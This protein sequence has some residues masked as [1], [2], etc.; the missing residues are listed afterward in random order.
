[1]KGEKVVRK[2]L[3]AILLVCCLIAPILFRNPLEAEAATDP[4]GFNLKTPEDFKPDDGENPYGDG[5]VAL[6]PKM[7]PFVMRSANSYLHVDYWNDVKPDESNGI[8][9]GDQVRLVNRN[10][11]CAADYVV[12]KAYDPDGDGHDYMVAAVGLQDQDLVLWN[13]NSRTKQ[14]GPDK[15]VASFSG[16]A[17]DWFDD[18][19]QWEYT[20]FFNLTAG[21]FDGDGKDELAVYVPMRG[22]PYVSILEQ[23]GNT[24]DEVD[25]VHYTTFMPGADISNT[26]TNDG[27]TERAMVQASLEAADMDRDGKDE[28]IFLGSF[29]NLH[30][31]DDTKKI[32]D[33]SSTLAIY[34]DND[35]D[36]LFMENWKTF[37]LNNRDSTEFDTTPI[38][39]RTASC[40]AGDIDYDGFPEI[41]VAGYYVD[42]ADAMED[43]LNGDMFALQTLD[44]EPAS[45][46]GKLGEVSAGTIRTV[47][48]NGWVDGGLYTGDDIQAPPA[49]TCVAANGRNAKEQVFLEGAMY[50]FADSG[51]T[52]KATAS[53]CQDGQDWQWGYM[54]SNTYVESAVAGNFDGN[55]MGIEQVYF[56][57]GYKQTATN[58]YFY[59]LCVMGK[60]G[61]GETTD[62]DYYDKRWSTVH[63]HKNQKDHLFLTVAAVDA[64][65]DTDTI[66]Y[67]RKEYTYT[68]ANVMAV[69][70]AAPYFED[71]KD[72]Y[73]DGVGETVFGRTTGSGGSTSTTKSASAGAYFNVEIP[74]FLFIKMDIGATYTHD[75]EWEYE[76]EAS[77]EYSIDFAG[78]Q[79]E[80]SVV[81]YRT[82]MTLYYYDVYPAGGGET[83]HMTV[84]VPDSPVYSIMSKEEYNAVAATDEN[85]KDKVITSNVLSSTPGQPSTYNNSAAGLK[86]FTGYQEFSSATATSTGNIS[87]SITKGSQESSSQSYNNTFELSIGVSGGP[88]G[89]G[90][91]GGGGWGGGSTTFE[92]EEVSKT[93]MVANPPQSEY[94]YSFQWKFGT[95][96]ADLGDTQVPV[97]GYIVNNVIEPPSLPQNIAV[98]SVTQDSITLTWDHG[99]RRP[100]TYEIYQYF[101]DNVGD[102]GYSLVATVD[103]NEKTFTY[104]GLKPGNSYSLALRS[105]GADENGEKTM[106][107]YSALVTGTTLQ[108]G[109]ELSVDSITEEVNVCPGDTAVFEVEATPSQGA[110]NGLS[111]S[112]QVQEEDSATWENVQSGNSRLIL[113][114]VTEEMD[115]NRYRCIVSEIQNG[116]RYYVYS[117]VGVL[118]VGKA[119]SSVS[120]ATY[121]DYDN[122]AKKKTNTGSA[123]YVLAEQGEATETEVIKTISVKTPA[124]VDKDGATRNESVTANYQVFENTLYQAESVY[125]EAPDDNQIEPCIYYCE[126]DNAYYALINLKEEDGTGTADKRILLTKLDDYFAT[127]KAGTTV[128]SGL[129]PEDLQGAQEVYTI[130]TKGTDGQETEGKRY[131]TWQVVQ[132]FEDTVTDEEGISKD[133]IR[134]E[135]LFLLYSEV[136]DA[137]DDSDAGETGESGNGEEPTYYRLVNDA[138]ESWNGKDDSGKD[139][140]FGEDSDYGLVPVYASEPGTE[141]FNGTTYDVWTDRTDNTN[142]EE[143]TI[144]QKEDGTYYQK[145]TNDDNTEVME[146]IYLITGNLTGTEKGEEGETAVIYPANP[147]ANPVMVME[148]YTPVTYTDQ[149]GKQVTLEAKVTHTQNEGET[150]KSVAGQVMF[151]IVNNRTGEVTTLSGEANKDGLVSVNWTPK[152]AGYYTITATFGGNDVLHPSSASTE[153][154]ATDGPGASVGY[155]LTKE[156]TGDVIYGDNVDLELKK[157]EVNEDGNVIL[158]TPENNVSV[159]YR[160]QYVDLDKVEAEETTGS[161][162][163]SGNDEEANK[164]A[165]KNET[166]SGGNAQG[167]SYTPDNM[168]GTHTFT[169]TV[170]EG[171]NTYTASLSVNVLKRPI[172]MTAPSTEEPLSVNSQDKIPKLSQ[173][174]VTYTGDETKNA[175]AAEEDATTYA[176][177]NVLQNVIT[178]PVLNANSGA[179]NYVTSLAYQTTGEG[180][181]EQNTEVVQQFLNRYDVTLE[182]GLY[183]IESGIYDVTYAAG[184]NGSLQALKD[185]NQVAFTSGAGLTEGTEVRF[186][187]HPDE[188]FKVDT[189]TVNGDSVTEDT[190]EYKLTGNGEK[191]IFKNLSKNLDVKVTFEPASYELSYLVDNDSADNGTISAQYLTEEGTGTS[192]QSG[193]D[194]FSGSGVR[195]TAE[196][197]DGY[198]VDQWTIRRDGEEQ[199]QVQKNEDGSDYAKNTLDIAEMDSNMT[200]TV[201]FEEKGEPFAITTSMVGEDGNQIAGGSIEVTGDGYIADETNE[202]AGTAVKGSEVTFT[203]NLPD[204]MIVREWRISDGEGTMYDEGDQEYEVV[205]GSQDTYTVYNVQSNLKVQVMATTMQPFKVTYGTDP[206]T[207]GNGKI[208]SLQGIKSG[209][210]VDKYYYDTLE[211]QISPK[212]GYEI[213]TIAVKM[214]AQTVSGGE[215]PSTDASGTGG[216]V[217]TGNENALTYKTE[218]IDNS[219]DRKLIVSP[220]EG[221]FSD[222]VEVTVSFKQITPCVDVRYS[223]HDLGDGTHGTMTAAVDR[224]GDE[225]YVETGTAVGTGSGTGDAGSDLETATLKGVYRDSVITF[226]AKPDAGYR[227]GKWTV[228]GVE[229]TEGVSGNTFTY[230]ITDE[231]K[232]PITVVAQMEWIGNQVTFGGVNVLEGEEPVGGTVSAYNNETG[233]AF[234][235]GNTLGIDSSL[236]FTAAPAAGYEVVG[237]RV[238][239]EEV[240]DGVSADK[241]TFTSQIQANGFTEVQAV[242]DQIPYTVN[243]SAEGGTVTVKNTSE[244]NADVTNGSEVRGGRTLAFT[245]AANTGMEFSG[246]SVTGADIDAEK[247]NTSPL[248]LTIGSDV[249]V[250]ANFKM[251]DEFALNFGSN[252]EDGSM[253]TLTAKVGDKTLTS[254]EKIPSNSKVTFTAAP[255]EGYLV[256]GWYSNATTMTEETKITGTEY[257][258]NEYVLDGLN[259][260]T[261]VYV[262]FEKI[263]SYNITVDTD[264]TGSGSLEVFVD[265]KA[266]TP[267]NTGTEADDT[268]AGTDG[269]GIYSVK[270]HSKVEVKATPKN[271]FHKLGAWN[272]KKAESDT[273]IIEDVKGEAS[274]TATF[275]ARE[276]VKVEFAQTEP[277]WNPSVKVGTGDDHEQYETINAV[278]TSVDVVRGENVLFEVTPPTDKMI[279]SWT[280][281]YD[282]Q[283]VE[284]VTGRE[285]GLYNTLLVENAEKNMTVSV[286]LREI[287]AHGVPANGDYDSDNDNVNDYTITDQTVTP[288]VLT[289]QQ[290][291]NKV[292]DN[293]DVTFLVTPAKGKWITDIRLAPESDGEDG[294]P[295]EIIIGERKAKAL[296]GEKSGEEENILSY[297]K[298]ADNSCT[299]TIRNVTRDV[300]LIVDTVNYHTVSMDNP[301]HGT[302][303]ARDAAGNVIKNGDNVAEGTVI[304]FTAAPEKHYRFNAWG[305][306]AAQY[307]DQSK[308]V[309]SV[310]AGENRGRSVE[311]TMTVEGN[312]TVSAGFA[313]TDHMNTEIRGAK[314]ATCTENGYTGDTYCKDCGTVLKKGT[315]IPA[316]GHTYSS[317]VTTEP[318]T[319]KAGVRTYT[320]SRCGHSYTEGV[321]TLPKPMIAKPIKAGRTKNRIS[322]KKVSGADGY[323]VLADHCNTRSKKAELAVKNVKTILSAKKTSWIHKRLKPAT[324]YKYQIKAF[325]LV[326]GKRVVISETPVIHAITSGSSRYANPVKVKVQKAKISVKE[327]KKKKIKASVILSPNRI[328]QQHTDVIRYVVEDKT[329]AT[330]NRKGVI[331]AKSR[332]K[333]AVWAVAQNGVSK[334]ITVTVK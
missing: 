179:N 287:E 27:K 206:E 192:I 173:V 104:D 251:K 213:D 41:V 54:I 288:D 326:N 121:H 82:P 90:T 258:Q 132:Y 96:R 276:T 50:E 238:N 156:Q 189:W 92:Y 264:G 279:D 293:G 193:A 212:V 309:G 23:T 281:E 219:A 113:N 231:A 270:R 177:E 78:G 321:E 1:M 105:V 73:Y 26:F 303:T 47:A 52:T 37:K 313:M 240:T 198:V 190:A 215:M 304:T 83:S 66:K 65:D 21:D 175:Y 30:D 114:N 135:P 46:A 246:W 85:M 5:K 143:I 253:G 329:I 102:N 292:R 209:A 77:I 261:N 20:S 71:L 194:V 110:M 324:W 13:Y 202:A 55:D 314:D 146:Q 234:S 216:S 131:R 289:D 223:L 245:A 108:E 64:D 112:W 211:F 243:W 88:V 118:H 158:E 19:D 94:P 191:L 226:T 11:Q 106:S 323:I 15:V 181:N 284:T 109:S 259:N 125:T 123:D 312:L 229:V 186:V 167:V 38:H 142:G 80:D 237:W 235:S 170:T 35:D 274:V 147:S 63:D 275:Q 210:T 130:S 244:G 165:L 174:S 172:T 225:A 48:M 115:G 320:C 263:P 331:K 217:Q 285:L 250:T 169:A 255:A 129:R 18:I 2:K 300:N 31:D 184:A 214:G 204:N 322:W 87:Q 151:Q 68:D 28:L 33:R 260:D 117:K 319:Q 140:S 97:L 25:T 333:T 160:V 155:V 325:K 176:K 182:S 9:S 69:L 301:Q 157:A 273:F 224:L 252:S 296:S 236:T 101:E 195:L 178:T 153:Y 93:G 180:D 148:Q 248:N 262:K 29:A 199:P 3:I 154:Y 56:T 45:E 291:D 187:A 241:K 328:C 111:Y 133:V 295:E 36:R 8:S 42:D 84:G 280:I 188:N 197:A 10:S 218:A 315:A 134:E 40:A 272:G 249:T 122:T 119:D 159:E 17:F 164:G 185:N 299:V 39:I 306:D 89:G 124:T 283:N 233:E 207:T 220:G 317:A 302:L 330:V 152:T 136:P 196:P 81:L 256:E 257:E 162:T 44:Y 227:V 316:L 150:K 12:T 221:G 163:E 230:E 107:E 208:T 74:I 307:A 22:D 201:S 4:Y 67:K 310:P 127:D 222:N 203:A 318:T 24:Y 91:T 277:S 141:E 305:K 278:G 232:E 282:G 43:E 72:Q 7:E 286:T 16:D 60:H 137:G 99:A 70:Q 294:E 171:E 98:S 308:E 128:I 59:D 334:K 168:S 166:I 126:S 327:G 247:L 267:V 145:V 228:N 144:Y 254:G 297:T 290:Y 205:A 58:H 79:M 138:M 311:L 32:T 200:V 62:G 265:G 51:W 86:D 120:V 53:F 6:N 116:E 161:G 239:G 149:P 183:Q 269:T 266:V 139:I 61:D 268:T 100:V 57:R 95:W 49:L 298:N 75:W 14:Q 103:G 332:G 76:K 271:K 242:F 34:R